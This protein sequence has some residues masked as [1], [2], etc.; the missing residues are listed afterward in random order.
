MFDYHPTTLMEPLCDVE[1]NGHSVNLPHL[2]SVGNNIQ[3]HSSNILGD[4]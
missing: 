2:K 1:A 4:R 3:P